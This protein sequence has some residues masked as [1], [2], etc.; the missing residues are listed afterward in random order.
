MGSVFLV[1]GLA[2]NAEKAASMLHSLAPEVRFHELSEA[3]WAAASEDVLFH[4]P[5]ATLNCL[6]QQSL[7][8]LQL[9]CSVHVKQCPWHVS[10]VSADTCHGP[11]P[12]DSRPL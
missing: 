7:H 3:C 8:W 4:V 5:Y 11:L 12:P 9:A 2:G 1:Q 10:A 6:S